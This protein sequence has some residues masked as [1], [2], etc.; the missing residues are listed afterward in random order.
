MTN[1]KAY[2]RAYRAK[3]KE[4]IKKRRAEIGTSPKAKRK[5]LLWYKKNRR[6]NTLLNLLRWN[7]LG[8]DVKEY[9]IFTESEKKYIKSMNL[10][11][12]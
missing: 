9:L 10:T 5:H 1:T 3:N 7:L 12:N 2:Q 6:L 11:T 4:Y 8:R